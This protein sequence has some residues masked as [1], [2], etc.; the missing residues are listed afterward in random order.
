M[1]GIEPASGG[2]RGRAGPSLRYPQTGSRTAERTGS[3]ATGCTAATMWLARRLASAPT[4]PSPPGI[5][6][7]RSSG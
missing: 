7:S 6:G 4:M 1:L 2:P 3:P 5:G